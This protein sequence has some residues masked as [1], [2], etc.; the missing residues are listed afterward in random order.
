MKKRVLAFIIATVMV[1]SFDSVKKVQAE[2]NDATA[3]T[4]AEQSEINDKCNELKSVEEEIANLEDE[5]SKLDNDISNLQSEIEATGEDIK[6]AQKNIEEKEEEIQETQ[7]LYG[8]RL[9]AYYENKQ[10][11]LDIIRVF[12]DSD[13][14]SDFI[15]KITTAKQVF[16]MD[17][18]ISE[19][20]SNQQEELQNKKQELEDIQKKN[21]ESMDKLK[22]AKKES[23]K[24]LKE[25][26]EKKKSIQEDLAQTEMGVLEVP[27][28]VISTSKSVENIQSAISILEKLQDKFK[29]KEARALI[30]NNI[31]IGKQK[32]IKYKDMELNGEDLEQS[33]SDKLV[34]DSYKYLGIEYVWGGKTPKGFDCSGFVGWVYKEVTG[35]DIGWCTY[36]QVF[37]G[38]EVSK[39]NIK[40]G[41]LLF[42]GDKLAPHHVAM[43]VGNGK[44]IHA[45]HTGDVI[46]ISYGIDKASV[47]KHII[48]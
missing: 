31:E 43:Y 29:T 10:S 16:D 27:I 17:T 46:K 14:F 19:D 47:I 23:D 39:E 12:L 45:P 15:T 9:R 40:P 41:D 37:S 1:F 35:I 4:E 20:L 5:L 7:E 2:P 13:G 48:D 34:L 8:G 30:S 24:L 25:L 28:C 26:E 36:T 33:M 32:I 21:S 22:N 11:F 6:E 44:Y 3:I 38:V 18:E 42:F